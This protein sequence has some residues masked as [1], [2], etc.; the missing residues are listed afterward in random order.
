[1]TV[2]Y[3]INLFKDPYRIKILSYIP[4]E[5][6]NKIINHESEVLNFF[7]W[8]D[9][10]EG[11]EYWAKIYSDLKK[12]NHDYLLEMKEA[13]IGEYLNLLVG[14]S[15]FLALEN[16]KEQHTNL[17]SKISSLSQAI[18]TAFIW[19][20]TVQ[21]HQ[22]WYDIVQR[23]EHYDNLSGLVDMSLLKKDNRY[24]LK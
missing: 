17:E 23:I 7:S 21:E 18:S 16:A 13:S 15:K 11:V 24:K 6:H 9:T 14:E 5:N 1:M 4:K 8:I 12:G 10:P 19:G 20:G 3:V 2:I 22:Y